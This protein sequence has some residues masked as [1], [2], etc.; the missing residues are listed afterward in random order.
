MLNTF[1]IRTFP[2]SFL[3]ESLH[4]KARTVSLQVILSMKLSNSCSRL[5]PAP[6]AWRWKLGLVKF[7]VW[8]MHTHSKFVV[9]FM[10]PKARTVSL[11]YGSCTLTGHRNLGSTN[12][13][14]SV[15]FQMCEMKL[16]ISF[17][18]IGGVCGVVGTLNS[19]LTSQAG[20]VRWAAGSGVRCWY[21]CWFRQSSVPSKF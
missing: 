20:P 4:P 10:H 2:L 13:L 9:W 15:W 14:V 16:R 17:G 7:V 11:L 5:V 6:L 21:L 12:P 1:G 8:F 18:T 19:I 3:I